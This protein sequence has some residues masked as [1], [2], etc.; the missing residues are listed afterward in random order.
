MKTF[1]QY[2]KTKKEDEL[3]HVFMGL[4]RYLSRLDSLLKEKVDTHS[5]GSNNDLAHELDKNSKPNLNDDESK[6]VREYT[7][8]SS[9][10]INK[11]LRGE[12]GKKHT[13]TIHHISN[14]I[15]RHTLHRDTTV[16]T[17]LH[18]SPEKHRDSS[19][20]LTFKNSGFTSTS[21]QRNIAMRMAGRQSENTTVNKLREHIEYGDNE[22]AKK[23]L[24]QHHIYFHHSAD[25]RH[26]PSHKHGEKFNLN[27]NSHIDTL[28]LRG[29]SHTGGEWRAADHVIQTTLPKG[30]HAL[31]IGKHHSNHDEGEVLLHHGAQFHVHKTEVVSNPDHDKPRDKPS[32]K[33]VHH[34]TITHDGVKHT[35]LKP[36]RRKGF[37]SRL[38]S[39]K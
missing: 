31:W 20:Q 11:Q 28:K 22:K 32:F 38:L 10:D 34:A 14:A 2:I 39:R 6:H 17:G 15:K 13:D 37:F 12:G 27:N 1:K 21:I 8:Y 19:G 36:P 33:V 9:A 5:L 4:P 35:G 26:S 24:K 30:S 29:A 3:P 7:G 18:S 25:T 16:Y 23:L